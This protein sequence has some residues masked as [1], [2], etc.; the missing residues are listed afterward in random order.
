MTVRQNMSTADL[1]WRGLESIPGFS[2]E[3]RKAEADLKA[4]KGVPFSEVR[5]GR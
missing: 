2:E 3:L 1:V 5:R 4:G